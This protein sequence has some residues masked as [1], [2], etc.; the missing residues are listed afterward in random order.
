MPV[1]GGTTLKLSNADC[2]QRVAL[3]IAREFH[4]GVLAQGIR[5]AEEIDLHRVIDHQ[6]GGEQW[7]DFLGTAAHRLHR[8]A[9]GGKIHDAGNPSEILQ[10]HARR[11]E[12]DL[13]LAGL[14]RLPAGQGLHV[15]GIDRL[16]VLVA[17]QV[18]E[19]DLQ[20]VGKALHGE[21]G[22]LEPLE[23]VDRIAAVTDFERGA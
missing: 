16:V 12:R 10:Q 17:Q 14:L 3:L 8:V 9:H 4:L 6:L 1:S 7:I 23:A 19:Q 2:P 18:L 21:T 11:Q 15:V 22:R 20:R 5:R 13:A